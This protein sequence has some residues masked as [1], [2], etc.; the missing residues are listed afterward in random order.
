MAD[1]TL[2]KVEKAMDYLQSTDESFAQAK[3]SM[4]AGKERLKT[5]FAQCYL[6]ATGDN[7]KE[8]ESYAL[9]SKDYR[10]QLE[11]YEES[12][13]EYEIIR[14]KRLRAELLIEVWRSI[15]SARSKGV[16]T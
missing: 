4:T 2:Q 14:N 6:D 8:R 10:T 5:T 12:I 13:L 7:V 9:V 16:M 15:N 11:V 3:A 1:I